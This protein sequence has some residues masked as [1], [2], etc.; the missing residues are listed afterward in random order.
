M[1]QSTA[2]DTLR[3]IEEV[4]VDDGVL[5]VVN[6]G[7]M[8]ALR[9]GSIGYS[10]I[11]TD[12]SVYQPILE[13]PQQIVEAYSKGHTIK[14]AAILGGG[15]CT[16]PRFLI[17]RFSNTI[18]IDSVEYEPTIISLTRKYFLKGIDTDKLNLVN[19]DAFSF[20]RNT[21]KC[22]DF[23]LVDIFVGNIMSEKINTKEFISDLNLHTEEISLVIFNGYN[24]SSEL[25]ETLCD[26]GKPHFKTFTIIDEECHNRYIVFVKGN[27]DTSAFAASLIER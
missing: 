11:Y 2:E 22:Y 21:P 9:N 10:C 7:N 27:I 26:L 1:A 17:K 16:F 24:S 25:C 19:D 5:S 20:V 15:C 13:M 4:K 3:I 12:E 18:Q 8:L 14:Q 6:R 23:V